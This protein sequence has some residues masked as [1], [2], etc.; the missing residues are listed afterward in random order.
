MDKTIHEIHTASWKSVISQC[1][2]WSARPGSSGWHK[3]ESLKKPVIT[4]S[5]NYAG[6][7]MNFFPRTGGIR[8]PHTGISVC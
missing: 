3:M 2:A 1:Q 5:A 6:K 4:G 7:R 8:I